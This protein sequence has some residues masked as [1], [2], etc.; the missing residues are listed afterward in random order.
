MVISSTV[1]LVSKNKKLHTEN[2]HQKKKK[3]QRRIYMARG[4]VLLEA[5]GASHI[6]AT[7]TR[8]EGG[9]TKAAAKRPQQTV[10]KY[11]IYDLIEHTVRTYPKR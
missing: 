2:R 9:V 11:S 8:H 1:L 5:E 4:G 3:V 7:Q 10:H 6:Q